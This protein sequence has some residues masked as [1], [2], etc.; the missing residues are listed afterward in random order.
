M[1]IYRKYPDNNEWILYHVKKDQVPVRLSVIKRVFRDPN[2]ELRKAREEKK[3][4]KL[5]EIEVMLKYL[6]GEENAEEE[7]EQRIPRRK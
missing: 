5:S 7:E 2:E 1:N 3:Q 4:E 6:A